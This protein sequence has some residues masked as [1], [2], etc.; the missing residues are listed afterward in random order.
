MQIEIG[1]QL[2]FNRAGTTQGG[3]TGFGGGIYQSGGT[4]ILIHAEVTFNEANWVGGAGGGLCIA[5]GT[6]C[7]TKTTVYGNSADSD[8]DIFGPFT[9]C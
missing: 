4:L 1:S 6:A 5:G 7:L 9:I 2:V 3:P 8:P